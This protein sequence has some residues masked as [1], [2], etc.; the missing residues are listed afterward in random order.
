MKKFLFGI[1]TVF[2]LLVFATGFNAAPDSK[3]INIGSE[4]PGGHLANAE[5][6]VNFGGSNSG[7]YMLITF[8]ESLD[9]QS[10]I[11]CNLYDNYFQSKNNEGAVDFVAI[12]FDKD[13]T[14]FNEI[15]TNDSLDKQ[16]QYRPDNNLSMELRTAFELEN[17]MG[18]VLIDPRGIIV[19]YN[20]TLAYLS[21]L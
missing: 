5:T 19:A 18:S 16:R 13:A 9:A 14:L 8:W 3:K 7:R 11:D 12:N 17:G 21:T 4:M 20:P 15:V 2:T 1:A 10:R 6:S